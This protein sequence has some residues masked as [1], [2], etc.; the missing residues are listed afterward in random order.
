MYSQ[1]Q[2]HLSDYLSAAA[3]IV[4]AGDIP[5]EEF[6][7]AVQAQACLMAGINPDELLWHYAD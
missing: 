4:M 6:S 7:Q 2:N 3:D 5:D 1:F